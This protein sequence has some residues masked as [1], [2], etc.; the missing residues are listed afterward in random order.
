MVYHPCMAQP[1]ASM[2]FVAV[3]GAMVECLALSNIA[4]VTC[5]DRDAFSNC[6]AT[7]PFCQ[8]S[9]S[10]LFNWLRNVS[11]RLSLFPPR[12][13]FRKCLIGQRARAYPSSG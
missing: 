2:R 5:L 11:R 10:E 4:G 9:L 13:I 12:S 8:S 7:H 3:P 6:A 1:G